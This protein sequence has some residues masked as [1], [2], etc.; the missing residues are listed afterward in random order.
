MRRGLR[1]LAGG[2]DEER[3]DRGSVDWFISTARAAIG[4]QCSTLL[5]GIRWPCP[6]M[7]HAFPLRSLICPSSRH[8]GMA[9]G[10]D[11]AAA[12]LAPLLETAV[13]E[14]APPLSRLPLRRTVHKMYVSGILK[15]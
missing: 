12:S 15:K 8:P 13:V 9:L 7:L 3:D 5:D 14:A 4:A 6:E 10:F 2:H 1:E 11:I